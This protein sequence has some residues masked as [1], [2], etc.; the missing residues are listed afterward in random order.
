MN[1]FTLEDYRFQ[2]PNTASIPTLTQSGL[3]G[4]LLE[5]HDR[6]MVR[7]AQRRAMWNY[8][9]ELPFRGLSWMSGRITPP[10]PV[11]ARAWNSNWR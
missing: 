9:V 10:A 7:R 4:G 8:V 3:I 11:A 1:A 6:R 2:Y 5:R